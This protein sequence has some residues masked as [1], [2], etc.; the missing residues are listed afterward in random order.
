MRRRLSWLAVLMT[1]PLAR[2]APVR[3]QAAARARRP[4][5][6]RPA[7]ASGRPRTSQ[8]PEIEEGKFNVAMVLIGPHDDGG[9]SQAHYEGLQYVCE[10]V[11]DS[12]VAYIELVPE[13]ADSEQVFRSLARKGFDF[14]IGTSFGYMD[15]MATVAEE[16][17]DTTFLHLTGYKSNGKN[18]GNFFGAVE[19]MKYLAGMLAGSRA[20]ADG[21]PKIGYM[22]TFPIPEELRLGNAIMRGAK[23]DLPRVHDGRRASSTPGTTRS[24][25]RTAPPR[26]STPAPR[27]SSPAPTPGRRRRRRRRRASGASPTTTRAR[28]RSTPASPPRTGSGVRS[29]PGSPSR[30][31]P[32]PTRPATSTST[33]TPR[34]WACSASWTARRRS[35]ASPACRPRTS[36]RSR[37][38]SPRCSAG[39]VRPVRSS[40][41]GRSWTT[42][43][44]SSCRP[45]Q[46][47]EQSDLDQFPPGAPGAECKT[48]MYWWNEGITA[49][50]A[51]A[52]ARQSTARGRRSP[53]A[54]RVDR[55]V[56]DVG[57]QPGPHDRRPRPPPAIE[58]S[59]IVKSFPG[60]VAND[61]VDFAVRAGRGP[62]PARRERRRQDHADERPRRALPARRRPS[63]SSTARRS[64]SA[65]RATRSPRA[66]AWSTSTSR[67]SRRMTVTENVLLG[68]DQPRFRLDLPHDGGRGRSASPSEL[69]LHVDPRAHGLAVVRRRAAA[70]R[71]PQDA[72]PR[73][74]DPDPRRAD[75]RPRAA[76]GRG[77]VRHAASMTGGRPQRRL[78]QPQ[79]RRGPRDR[80]PDHGHARAAGSRPPARPQR[81][82]T[83]AELARLMVG[84]PVLEMPSAPPVRA[85]AG[86]PRRRAASRADNDRGLPALQG[87]VA[88]GPGRA[89]S[90][91][92]PRSPATARASSP[93]SSPG[94]GRA[95]AGSR[96]TARTSP[97]GRPTTRSARGVA[98]VPEDRTGVGSAP[99]LSIVDNLIMKRYRAEPVAARLVHGRRRGAAM[100]ERA[101]RQP[102][103]SRRPR[104]T[105]RPG[106]CRAATSSG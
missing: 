3:R 31:R 49:R 43:A 50:A 51:A 102:T 72:L 105:R 75:G 104:S 11:A 28:A 23:V 13:G 62:R 100:A 9:W 7:G 89:R 74:P 65:R 30:S 76:G 58:A 90:S 67:W 88:R 96:S 71:D 86:R 25:R 2:W 34:R 92:S 10:N 54:P 44:R 70:G 93:R 57:R 81:R 55:P 82:T 21:N 27:S 16:F 8:I 52:V 24:R 17:P 73:R 4:R 98:H 99:N 77:A 84:R 32:G 29:T 60:V 46:K 19:D 20:K 56:D 106:S 80:R 78:H 40:S 48:C 45:A 26:C 33:P 91:G 63:S 37:T 1:G 41:P 64:S 38:R 61:H 59:G 79:A 14:I 47:L 85:R 68:L 36:S 18:F 101:A 66:S 87:V 97:T 83:R 53:S 69:G 22:A 5:Q 6:M 12:H 42:P 94:C 35:R 15:P 103:R 95:P 39:D